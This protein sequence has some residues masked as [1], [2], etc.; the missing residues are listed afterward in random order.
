MTTIIVLLLITIT[1]SFWYG[2]KKAPPPWMRC[3]ESLFSQVILNRCTP[4]VMSIP[5]TEFEKQSNEQDQMQ[6]KEEKF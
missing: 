1:L 3:K 4:S 6:L 2:R 5:E